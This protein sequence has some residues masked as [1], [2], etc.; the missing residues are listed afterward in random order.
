MSKEEKNPGGS[1]GASYTVSAVDRALQLLLAISEMPESGVTDLADHTGSTK[2]LT[3]RL[4]YT[5][6]QRGF[7]RKDPDRRTYTLGYR[8]L[9][10]GDQSR[11]QSRLITTAEP[12]LAELSEATHE[13]VLLLVREGLHSVCISMRASPHP[14]RI[15]AAVGRS[16]P[17]HGGGGPK[18]LLAYAPEDVR[19]NILSGTLE[20]FTETTISDAAALEKTLG[21]IR[22]DGYVVSIGEL[23]KNIFSIAAPLR[24]QS[25]RVIAAISVNGPTARLDAAAQ[26]TMR[27]ALLSVTAQLSSVLGWREEVS[28]IG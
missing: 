27:D 16:A 12:F 3:F 22:R 10:L 6:E 14:L 26:L 7:V 17:L 13:N 20:S 28:V 4:L 8:A 11:L 21:Q 23:D 1:N 19:Q 25:G 15:F 2:S 5:L 18:V 9:L 24:D